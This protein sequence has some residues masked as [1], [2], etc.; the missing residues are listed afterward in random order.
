MKQPGLDRRHR[1]RSGEIDRKRSDTRLDTL[2]GTYGDEFAPGWAG[3]KTLGDLRSK[4]GKTLSE[5]LK[6]HNKK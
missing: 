2:L 3:D 6:E 5:L 1:D 4:T